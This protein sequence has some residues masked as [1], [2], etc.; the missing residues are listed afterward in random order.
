[1]ISQWRPTT[2]PSNP[3]PAPA[4]ARA[5]AASAYRAAERIEEHTSGEII[6]YTRKGGV[7]HTEIVL[8]SEAA[9]RDISW[10]RDR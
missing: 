2:S 3:S 1:L 9:K 7:E 8:S 5:T 6:D 10:T 4:T